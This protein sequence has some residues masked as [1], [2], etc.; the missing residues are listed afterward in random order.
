M[1]LWFSITFVV[2]QPWSQHEKQQLFYMNGFRFPVPSR[3]FVACSLQTTMSGVMQRWLQLLAD[4][5]QHSRGWVVNLWLFVVVT[6][7]D[8]Q[9]NAQSTWKLQCAYPVMMKEAHWAMILMH[10]TNIKC[11]T[12]N[13]M[14]TLKL[15]YTIL[16]LLCLIFPESNV[17]INIVRE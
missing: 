15:S 6:V 5:T 8:W 3:V 2:A 16:S 12:V 4:K 17:N 11:Y 7:F 9:G 10:K 14:F 13:N 1:A